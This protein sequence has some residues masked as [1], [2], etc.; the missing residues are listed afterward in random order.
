VKRLTRSRLK[1]VFWEDPSREQSME[2][3]TRRLWLQEGGFD[4]RQFTT[5]LRGIATN[6]TVDAREMEDLMLH[7]RCDCGKCRVTW[8]SWSLIRATVRI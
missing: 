3:P 1:K 7:K 8:V 2:T 6:A 4:V 5:D